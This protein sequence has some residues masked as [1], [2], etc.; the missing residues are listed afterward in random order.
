MN[1]LKPDANEANCPAIASLLR[2]S[3]PEL[4]Q[5]AF[6][7]AEAAMTKE[8]AVNLPL[9]F[10]ALLGAVPQHTSNN[11][12]TPI[13]I[14]EHIC[15]EFWYE[16]KKYKNKDGGESPFYA[17]QDYTPVMD[18]LFTTLRNYLAPVGKSVVP[19]SMTTV[20]D[21]F[22]QVISFKLTIKWRWYPCEDNDETDRRIKILF[23]VN[24]DIPCDPCEEMEK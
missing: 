12:E 19:T 14:L 24:P 3:F 7:V 11:V 17:Y 23:S 16:P 13:D 20:S 9:A 22:A 15:I 1:V 2:A 4:K 5:R 21:E 10:V 18:K 6:A 8:N